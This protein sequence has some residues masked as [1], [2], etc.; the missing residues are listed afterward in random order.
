M[1]GMWAGVC[2]A[3]VKAAPEELVI[4][5]Q[6]THVQC[7]THQSYQVWREGSVDVICRKPATV[8]HYRSLKMRK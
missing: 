8:A 3:G 5:M 4:K 6:S 2:C 7:V 1:C